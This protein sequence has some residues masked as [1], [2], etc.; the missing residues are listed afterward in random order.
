MEEVNGSHYDLDAWTAFWATGHAVHNTGNII[1][2]LCLLVL[3]SS[4]VMD[5]FVNMQSRESS[6]FALAYV[7]L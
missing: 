1:A 6:G 4:G 2:S 7:S 5:G 3:L